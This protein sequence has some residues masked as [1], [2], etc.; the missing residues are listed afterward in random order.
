MAKFVEHNPKLD[1]KDKILNKHIERSQ[2]LT[3][4]LPRPEDENSNT[5]IGYNT[6][7]WSMGATNCLPKP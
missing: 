3:I 2:N 1:P 7:A 6:D 5:P 4:G